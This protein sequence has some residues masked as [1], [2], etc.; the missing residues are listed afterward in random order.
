MSPVWILA[1]VIVA[2]LG[3]GLVVYLSSS[4]GG[5]SSSSSGAGSGTQQRTSAAD[6]FAAVGSGVTAGGTAI[7]GFAEGEG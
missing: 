6:L 3:I 1:I 5:S 4:G 2:I 7:A